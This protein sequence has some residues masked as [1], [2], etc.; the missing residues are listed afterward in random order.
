M[1]HDGGKK[2]ETGLN[3]FFLSNTDGKKTMP[4]R[5]S[6]VTAKRLLNE[7]MSLHNAVLR[8]AHRETGGLVDA[9]VYKMVHRHVSRALK[10]FCVSAEE[11]AAAAFLGSD[12]RYVARIGEKTRILRMIQRSE[13]PRPGGLIAFHVWDGPP[14]AEGEDRARDRCQVNGGVAEDS[15]VTANVPGFG[16]VTFTM[17]RDDD[18]ELDVDGNVRVTAQAAQRRGQ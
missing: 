18:D 11:A 9:G 4:C 17:P 7:A 10:R 14:T 2:T 8:E 12:T 1:L 16:R 3:G 5:A 15:T 13:L 6:R